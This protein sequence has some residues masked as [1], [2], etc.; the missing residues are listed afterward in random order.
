[1]LLNWEKLS[2]EYREAPV[3]LSESIACDSAKQKIFLSHRF[4]DKEKV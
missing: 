2:S 3:K 1:M 4:L